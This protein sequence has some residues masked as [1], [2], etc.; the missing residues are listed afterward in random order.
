MNRKSFLA[1][2]CSIIL[3]GVGVIN[4]YTTNANVSNLVM[5]NV[6]ALTEIPEELVP[7]GYFVFHMPQFN[8]YGQTTGLCSASCSPMYNSRGNSSKC[9][10]HGYNFCCH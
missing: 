4:G 6:E 7:M 3:C 2:S 10:S 1:L 5:D 9:H 8:K